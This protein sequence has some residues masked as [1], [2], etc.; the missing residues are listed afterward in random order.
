MKRCEMKTNSNR[1]IFT[2]IELLV[3]VAIIAILAALLLPALGRAREQAKMITCA[4][5]L[6]QW[7]LGISNYHDAFNDY[8][9]PQMMAREIGTPA[10]VNWYVYESWLVQQMRPGITK[11]YWDAAKDINGCPSWQK[12]R[13]AVGPHESYCMNYTIDPY[14]KVVNPTGGIQ[15]IKLNQLPNPSRVMYLVDSDVDGAGLNQTYDQYINQ[16]NDDCRVAYRH[17]NGANILAAAGN[18]I[19]T[20]KRVPQVTYGDPAMSS[21]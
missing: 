12:L 11:T 18:I 10:M 1:Q 20:V 9:L 8:L 2:L 4:N 17:S 3:V 14:S 6:K 21:Y 15:F 13:H 19:A 5:N 16:A 7:Y